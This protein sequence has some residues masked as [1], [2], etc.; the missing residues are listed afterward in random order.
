MANAARLEAIARFVAAHAD[1]D[2]TEIPCGVDFESDG[3]YVDLYWSITGESRAYR[4]N[5]GAFGP[6]VPRRSMADGGM[7]HW[8]LSGRYDFIDLTDIA[9]GA[10]RGEQSAYAV[11]LDWIPIDHVRFK[12]NYAVSEMD[13]TAAADDEATVITLRSQFDF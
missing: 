8:M 5:Q 6:I 10:N 2:V 4:G 3:Y 7:G 12:L 11:G 1:T 13:R 9:F